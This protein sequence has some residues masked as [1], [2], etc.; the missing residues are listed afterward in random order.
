MA[1]GEIS[2]EATIDTRDYDKGT[3]QIE[4]DNKKI[5]D[6]AEK[7][8]EKVDDS[9]EKI[10]ESTKKI[11]DSSKSASKGFS[12]S[13]GVIA[14]VAGTVASKVVDFVGDLSSS[15]IE[16]SDSAQKFSSTMQF[17]GIDDKKIQEL[18][19]STQEYADKT[20]FN[21]AD[22][23]NATAQLASNSVKDYDKLAE[24]A[25]NLTA[26]A[27]GG[28]NEFKSVAMVLTQTAGAGK[29][30][31][32]NW[33]Q[34]SDA[35]PGASGKLQEAMLK[36]G[37]YTGNF[38]DAMEDGQ[39]TAE[40]FNQAIM[41]LGMTDVAKEAATSTQTIEGAWG[42]LEA[43][44]VSLGSGVLDAVKPLITGG[45]DA[46][47][48]FVGDASTNFQNF[49][50][51]VKKTMDEASK[52]E[53]FQKLK[54]A[55]SDLGGAFQNLYNAVSSIA[56]PLVDQVTGFVEP[57]RQ[58]LSSM[59][60]DDLN[61]KISSIAGI[62]QGVADAINGLASVIND[63]P[64]LQSG[65][66]AIAGAL[67]A[68]GVSSALTVLAG[69]PAAI[70]AVGAALTSALTAIGIALMANPIGLVIGLIGASIGMLVYFFTQ[71]EEGKQMW[72]DFT[73]FLNETLPK[74]QQWFS[75]TG[76]HI[77]DAFSQASDFVQSIP[78]KIEGF[79]NGI[80]D[81][82]KNIFGNVK[83]G[84]TDAFN[85]AVGFVQGIP[86]KI[87]GFFAGIP[88]WFSSKF[89]EMK[90]SVQNKFNEVVSFV[91]GIPG[92]IKSALGN[93]GGILRN[94]GASIINGFLNGLKS[95]WGKVTDFVGGIA[96]W[97]ASHKGPIS[98][99]RKL[100]IP[101][102]EA[103]MGGL[104]KSMLAGWAQIQHDVASMGFGIR[105]DFTANARMVGVNPVSPVPSIENND[106]S[107]NRSITITQ[108][109]S[110]NDPRT[111]ATLA[112]EYLRRTL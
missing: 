33:N 110:S 105:N 59:I 85:G 97:I 45:M 24:A 73:N 106:V 23:R 87:Q 84:V 96:G 43:S 76:Q 103:I 32:E 54:D 27:G 101:A 107:N 28:A 3:K 5:Q 31:T 98:Y 57:I 42:N 41:D 17:A 8:S 25:G 4:S 51:N 77:M 65:L 93:V 35:I 89:G 53:G 63:N 19:K 66:Y 104:R 40:E 90:N 46:I 6:S 95:A 34:L 80:A 82:F 83:Q 11:P 61:G 112:N 48:Q 86:G 67:T 92:K 64:M 10:S 29:L 108:N 13:F 99:D 1:D 72:E 26:V 62:V 20:V 2:L 58:K 91:R 69:L 75:D 74:I 109:I 12:A 16:A 100:L 70:A 49:V 15:I 44:F 22:I 111:T 21:L 50:D 79:F 38:R 39:I 60:P 55:L 78:G 7:T 102:G 56:Q 47:S 30:T 71:T 37:A 52:T 9:T 36:N 68:I 81:W 88:S 94:A 14:G 18:T